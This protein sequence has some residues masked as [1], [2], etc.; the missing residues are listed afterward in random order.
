MDTKKKIVSLRYKLVLLFGLLILSAGVI[1]GL[2]AVRT[3]RKAVIEKI[4]AHLID[5]ATDVAEIVDGRLSA[6]MQFIEGLARMPFLRD[7][8]L[9]LHQQAQA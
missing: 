2:L 3:A 8:S 6:M 7:S 4:E 9:S 1:M 5:K